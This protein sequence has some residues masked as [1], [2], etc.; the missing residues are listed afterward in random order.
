MRA[1]VFVLVLGPFCNWRLK[2][3]KET[4]DIVIYC[5]LIGREECRIGRIVLSFSIFYPFTWVKKNFYKINFVYVFFNCFF[6]F[7]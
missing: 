2:I 4:L 1:K 6:N 7:N 3:M 5:N